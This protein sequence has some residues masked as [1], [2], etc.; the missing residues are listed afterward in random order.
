[1]VTQ[2]RKIPTFEELLKRAKQPKVSDAVTEERD[3]P[4]LGF[5]P[6]PGFKAQGDGTLLSPRGITF[7]NIKVENGKITDFDA[8][9]GDRPV[10]VPSQRPAP[11]T[12]DVVTPSRPF[13]GLRPLAEEPLDRG[14]GVQPPPVQPSTQPLEPTEPLIPFGETPPVSPVSDVVTAPF[15]GQEQARRI[16]LP[17]EAM[18]LIDERA[19]SQAIA[20]GQNFYQSTIRGRLLGKQSVE[21]SVLGFPLTRPVPTFTVPSLVE[22]GKAEQIVISTGQPFKGETETIDPETGRFPSDDVSDDGVMERFRERLRQNPNPLIR[23]AN[24]PTEIFGLTPADI[25]GIGLIITGGVQAIRALRSLTG[26]KRLPQYKAVEQLAKDKKIPKDSPV[27][28]DVLNQIRTAYNFYK[29]GSTELAEEIMAQFNASYNQYWSKGV[30]PPR[31]QLP[32]LTSGAPAIVPRGTQ[33]GAMAFGGL[34]REVP[35]VQSVVAKIASNQAL[36]PADRQ[37]YASQSQ[38]VEAALQELRPIPPVLPTV[39]RE[40][41]TGRFAVTLRSIGDSLTEE[42]FTEAGNL[43]PQ[44]KTQLIA[45]VVEAIDNKILSIEE[46]GVILN[47]Y[48][49]HSLLNQGDYEGFIAYWKGRPPTVPPSKPAQPM[50]ED[51]INKLV[52][53]VEVRPEA[54]VAPEVAPT[55]DLTEALIGDA[56]SI[57]SQAE[58]VQPDNPQVQEMR[59]LVD[60]AKTATGEARRE[61]LINIEAIEEEVKGIAGI[62]EAPTQAVVPQV[63][64]QTLPVSEVSKLETRI[65]LDLIRKDEV[66]E[67][68]R[69]TEEIRAEGIKEPIVIRIRDD[70]TQIVWDGIHRLI[71]AQDLGLENI[72]VRFIGDEGVSARRPPTK[73]QPTPPA[74]TPTEVPEVTPAPIEPADVNIVFNKFKGAKGQGGRVELNINEVEAVRQFI[75]ENGDLDHRF[76]G[77]AYTSFGDIEIILGVFTDSEFVAGSASGRAGG[78]YLVYNTKSNTFGTHST[79]PNMVQIR[80]GSKTFTGVLTQE[81][82][83]SRVRDWIEGKVPF[84]LQQPIAITEGIPPTPPAEIT[85]KPTPKAPRAKI[86]PVKKEVAPKAQVDIEKFKPILVTTQHQTPFVDTEGFSSNPNL[87]HNEKARQLVGKP[88]IG[89]YMKQTGSIRVS[90]GVGEINIEMQKTP[91][92]AQFKTLEVMAGDNKI[93]F[94]ISNTDMK[95]QESGTVDNFADFRKQVEASN[96][97]QPVKPTPKTLVE[98]RTEIQGL[99]KEPAKN[100]PKGTTKIELRKELAEINKSLIPQEKAIRSR[101]MAT[102]KGKSIGITQSRAIFRVTGGSR[103]LTNM[104]LTQLE[105]V[106]KAVEKARPIRIKGKIVITPKKEALIQSSKKDLMDQGIL[107]E[108]TYKDIL[109]SM[110]LSTDKYVDPQNFITNTQGSDI[111]RAMRNIAILNP[112]GELKFGKPTALKLLTSQTYYAQVLGVKPLTNPLELAKV[113]FDLAHRAMSVSIDNKLRE[114]NKAWGVSAGEIIKAKAKNVPTKGSSALRDLLDKNEEAPANLTDDQRELFNWFRNLNRSIINGENEV[115]RAMGVEEISYR[116]AYVRHIPDAMASSIIEGVHPLPQSLI[117]WAKKLVSKKIFNPMEL[118]RQLSD[119]LAEVYSKDLAF[120][121]KNMVFIGLKEIHLSQ[122]LRTFTEQMGALSDVMPASTRKWVTDYINQVIKGQQTE[123]DESVN[124]LVTEGGIGKLIDRVLV[125]FNRT[126]GN[127]PVSKLASTIGTGTIYSVLAAPRPRLARLMIRNMFQRTQELALHGVIPTLKSFLPDTKAIKDLK[128]ESRY[129]KGYTGI[130]EWPTDLLGKLGKI[131]LAP[132][133]FTATLNADRG[134]STAYHDYIKFFENKK[135]KDLGWVSEKRTYKEE[136][137]FLYPEEQKLMLEEME[138]ATRATQYQY[139]GMGMPEIF[140]HK[141]LIPLTRLQSWWMNHFTMFHRE[142]FHRFA[143]G[144]TRGGQ[145]LPW[146]SR[147]NWLKYLLFGGAILTAMGYGAS[148]GVKVLPHNESPFMQFA[149]GLSKYV[150]AGTDWERTQAKRSMFYSWKAIVPGALAFSEFEKLWSGEMPLWQMFF[151]G[152]EETGAP[153]RIPDWSLPISTLKKA[154][155]R[156]EILMSMLGEFDQA[157]LDDKLEKAE[158]AGA[159]PARLSEIK[160]GDYLYDITSLRRDMGDVV[161]N[162]D[163]KDIAK[164]EP[165]AR[166][167]VEFK[168][169]DKEYGLLSD[170]EQEQ[171]L[172]RTP[173]YTTNRLFWGEI[174]TIPDLHTARDVVA[175][176]EKYNIPLDMIP[177][178]QLTDD[179][180]ERIPSNRDLWKPYFDYYDLPGT[181]YLNMTQGQVDDGLLPEKHRKEWETYNKLKTDTARGLYRRTHKAAA[182]SKW[183]TDFRRA[184]RAFDQWLVDQEYNKSLPKRTTRR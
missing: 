132:Y 131:P 164:L 47:E 41:P 1:M 30:V 25:V 32:A 24:T 27:Y 87:I 83:E 19:R 180:K 15:P 16:S 136:K 110:K 184:N 66:T 29:Q 109:E 120:A 172:E 140:R 40:E 10:R 133:Q 89:E 156:I 61:A 23:A 152:S 78:Q 113:D 62:T 122:P 100:L 28:K 55:F 11:L 124:A 174:T 108:A 119:D 179:G 52:A 143:M 12:S 103:Y 13:P 72:P 158:V 71:V 35:T 54:Q 130:E 151:Y 48:I 18:L 170:K 59:R 97:L 176:A 161:R 31:T 138:L 9:K 34:P 98:R 2:R 182:Y 153:P 21:V 168:E 181:S 118:H 129:L 33:T 77:Q 7:K 155:P 93:N 139:I 37:F 162:L 67:I 63:T 58:A 68:A 166:N 94:D 50:T 134:M 86:S 81:E 14:T 45:D 149:I 17:D 135:Y 43:K 96:F 178:F 20:A 177:A 167:Y 157:E 148:F 115:R 160:A 142:A 107:T 175:L 51:E 84:P 39:A 150:S 90:G 38:E 3:F 154:E 111:I 165:I 112:L 95:V 183:R 147:V 104:E 92:D 64:P 117:F 73:P 8:F 75:L 141:T 173:I 46:G 65:P 80:E 163:E 116:Q 88:D 79:N 56:E 137:G 106:L 26:F 53:T 102:V 159:S 145:R 101:I 91:T 44:A 114:V 57:V 85:P 126:L 127:R 36:T 146:S 60:E 74:V 128:G 5:Q 69:L 22:G 123:W 82:F 144:E 42:N 99:L 6:P 105:K 121:T 70:G 76:A 125:P 49:S 169:R 171:Y 4:L